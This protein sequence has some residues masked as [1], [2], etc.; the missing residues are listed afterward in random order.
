M[1]DPDF[2][3]KF[4]KVDHKTREAGTHFEN[5]SDYADVVDMIKKDSVNS[6]QIYDILKTG[7]RYGMSWLG[8]TNRSYDDVVNHSIFGDQKLLNDNLKPMIAQLDERL[9]LFD[10]FN[11]VQVAKRK[12]FKGN[13]GDEL[14]IHKVN[15]G[16][17]DTAWSYMKKIEVDQDFHLYTILID[18]GGN[19]GINANDTLWVAASCLYLNDVLQS[20]GKNVQII[21]G[22]ASKRCYLNGY[23]SISTCSV[24][25]YNEHL[26][27]ERLGVM[28]NIAFYRSVGFM[29]KCVPEI[30]TDWG[31]G[32]SYT[33][34]EH[35]PFHL[36]DEIREGKTKVVN[37]PKSLNIDQAIKSI[38]RA[39]KDIIK[40]SK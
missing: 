7:N 19:A 6:D 31:L 4:V 38:R 15:Q 12:R 8:P 14:D 29:L 3:D 20:A 34:G 40:N 33:L 23:G 2:R 9:K 39:E 26:N 17:L 35:M 36:R 24:K 13:A 37:L 27:I 1:L 16:K 32:C 10:N 30:K 25:K 18:I 21:V 11:E 28:S 22:G 5:M